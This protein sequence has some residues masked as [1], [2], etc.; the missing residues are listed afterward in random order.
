[1]ADALGASDRPDVQ[2]LLASGYPH[3]PC[4]AY[5][6]LRVREGQGEAARA[7]LH[8]QVGEVTTAAG[9]TPTAFNVAFTYEGLSALGLPGDA[10]RTFPNNAM[11]A[12]AVATQLEETR[13]L[14]DHDPLTRL[15]NRRALLRELTATRKGITLAEIRDAL[16]AR[17]IASG[18]LTTIWS[19]LRRFDLS[20]KKRA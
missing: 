14:P 2:G 8:A 11:E 12:L 13:S 1:M 6:L 20:H 15:L 19:T 7:W 17:G 18:S 4:A 10:L 3:L 5:R 16:V 9:D